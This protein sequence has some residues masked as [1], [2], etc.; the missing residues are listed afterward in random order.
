MISS[1][2]A[3]IALVSRY[4]KYRTFPL[5]PLLVENRVSKLAFYGSSCMPGDFDLVSC[6]GRVT[7]AVGRVCKAHWRSATA[8]QQKPIKGS[9][10]QINSASG[11]PSRLLKP[12]RKTSSKQSG[13]A[14]PSTLDTPCNALLLRLFFSAN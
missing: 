7:I 1:G 6:E 10:F 12:T 14:A 3:S 5:L 2:I 8:S 11:F 9:H 13:S 4:L